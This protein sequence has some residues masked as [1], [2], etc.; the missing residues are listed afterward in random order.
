MIPMVMPN[1]KLAIQA[2]ICMSFKENVHELRI[3]RIHNTLHMEE[4]EISEALLKEANLNP[5]IQVLTPAK[6]LDF[7]SNGNLF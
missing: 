2:A 5:Q 1:Q 7:D 6:S 4:I 3:V